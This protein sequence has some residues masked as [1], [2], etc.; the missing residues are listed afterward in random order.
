MRILSISRCKLK[1]VFSSPMLAVVHVVKNILE[2]EGISCVI[3]S[4]YL[5]MEAGGPPPIYC[6]PKLFVDN[7]SDYQL[8]MDAIAKY[9]SSE[10]SSSAMWR[11]SK[12]G[13]PNEAQFDQ[14]WSCLGSAPPKK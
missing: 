14:C 12:C 6:W 7:E 2:S 4:E 9:Q 13:E 8:A 1:E 5:Q 3:S 10:T 11:C